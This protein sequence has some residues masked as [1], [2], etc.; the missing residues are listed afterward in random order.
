MSL[1]LSL[2][3]R[4]ELSAL[5]T[6]NGRPFMTV[7]QLLRS[8]AR[9]AD[10]FL[11]QLVET[12]QGLLETLGLSLNRRTVTHLLTEG[13][14]LSTLLS[15]DVN[16][17]VA[18]LAE[19]SDEGI[20]PFR[21]RQAQMVITAYKNNAVNGRKQEKELLATKDALNRVMAQWEVYAGALK[22]WKNINL[23]A[24]R[25]LTSGCQTVKVEDESC[26]F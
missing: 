23:W 2:D 25:G 7:R 14:S 9:G 6:L 24:K 19:G 16:V 18:K 11:R 12:E 1:A 3:V 22:T 4:T 26:E 5:S 15:A 13:V 20:N 17:E 8:S 21:Y 10:M